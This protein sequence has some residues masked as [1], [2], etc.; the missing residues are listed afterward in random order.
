MTRRRMPSFTTPGSSPS[1]GGVVIRRRNL[2]SVLT[3]AVLLAAVTLMAL[4]YPAPGHAQTTERQLLSNTGGNPLGNLNLGVIAGTKTVAQPFE[5]GENSTGYTL[6]KIQIQG[7]SAI[8]TAPS[9]DTITVTLRAD[10]S[11]EPANTAL[12]TFNPP[13]TWALNGLNDF[14]LTEVYEL[15]PETTYHIH[16]VT[17]VETCVGRRAANR[18]DANG[19]PDWSFSTR[20]ALNTDGDWEARTDAIA[21]RLRGAITPPPL[22]RQLLSNTDGN[23]LGNLNLGVIAGSK[24]VAQPFE[25]GE[26][27]T[28]YTLTKIQIQGSSGGCTTPS[29]DTITVTLRADTSG[30]PAYTALATFNPPETWAL[31]GLNDFAL[32][33]VY[34][35]DPQT[36]YHI[37]I[38]TTVETC[39]GRR[40]A[41]RVD[42]NGAPDWSFSTRTALNTDDDWEGRSDAIA[43]RLRGAITPPPLERQLLSNTDGTRSG[44]LLLGIFTGAKTVAQPFRTGQNSTGYTLT[45]I[46]IQGHSASC[47]TPSTD[48]ITVTLRADS[49]G[50]P[51]NTALATFNP[52]ETWALNGLNDFALTKVYELDPQTTYH[53]HIVTTVETCLGTRAANRVDANGAPDWSFST[54]TGLNTD[55]DWEARTDAIAMRLRGAITLRPATGAPTITGTAEV[56]QTLTAA[57]SGIMDSDGLTSPGYTYQW[58][59]VDGGTDAD[60]SGATSSAYT[61]VAADVGKT[62]KVRVS[63]TDDA[64]NPETLTSAATAA[65]TAINT[66]VSN[67]GQGDDGA[68][69]QD[70]VIA[71]NFTTGSK[72]GGYT[73]TIV[74]I[75][76]D[77]AEGD[78]FSA[79]IWTTN[80]DGDPVSQVAALTAP[81]SF[82]A[83]TLT[84]TAPANTTLS[85]STTYTVRIVHDSSVAT[86]DTTTSDAE[87]AGGASG[88]SIANDV[89]Y[90]GS[91][92][93]T[94]TNSEKSIR[95]AIKGNT[96]VKTLPGAPTGLTVTEG[97][98]AVKL[99]WTAPAD[100]GDSPITG[101]EYT[102]DDAITFVATGSTSTSLLVDTV[103]DVNGD[104][105][106]RVRA[107]NAVGSG[108]WSDVVV[109]RLGPATV[110]IAGGGRV[111][112]GEYA[113]FTLT[114][115]KPVL[116]RDSRMVVRVSSTESGGGGTCWPTTLKASGRR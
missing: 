95:I 33:K 88:W 94:T 65:V 49:S 82:A 46:Q 104:Y 114:A 19:A 20:T 8:C 44:Y 22:E 36:T 74:D 40:A 96:R 39:V 9:T 105:S 45:E 59:R 7:R 51:A 116:S 15:D 67:F 12:A 26:N 48:T 112:Q 63:F 35:L 101:Y 106:I 6:T 25:T 89:R 27:S 99:D 24:T 107:V 68:Y 54:R 86:M 18:V 50:E 3:A 58:I 81:S 69:A 73:V 80:S 47:T 100:N 29:T 37:H 52:P 93:W 84:F 42:A 28:G 43:M 108:D 66:Y 79:A 102:T 92:G 13:G 4:L 103:A 60:I 32:T 23:R 85:A 38:V 10:S 64:A 1:A 62:I 55:G 72:S 91:G 17:T 2:A 16:I 113:V 83:G 75:G 31:N 109:G 56:G 71:Q 34:E 30:D 115:S 90:E 11:G 77:D 76:S 41:N 14:T 61:L 21:M 87:D 53:I 57:T 5:T 70:S 98:R 111:V 110:T 78:A 97:H